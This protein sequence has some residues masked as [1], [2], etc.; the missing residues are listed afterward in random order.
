[1]DFWIWEKDGAGGTSYIGVKSLSVVLDET[2]IIQIVTEYIRG[3]EHCE[4]YDHS[5]EWNGIKKID[6]IEESATWMDLE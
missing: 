6:N 2:P 1:M 5:G 3:R 4:K